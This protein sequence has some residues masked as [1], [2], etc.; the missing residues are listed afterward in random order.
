MTTSYSPEL[1]SELN[2]YYGR[3]PDRVDTSARPRFVEQRGQVPYA[4]EILKNTDTVFTGPIPKI[5]LSACPPL[6][7]TFESGYNEPGGSFEL[8]PFPE[9]EESRFE[10][11]LLYQPRSNLIENV[12]DRVNERAQF[13]KKMSD[14]RR[15]YL[16]RYNMQREVARTQ[17]FR[18]PEY[19]RIERGKYDDYPRTVT[20]FY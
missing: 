12:G 11:P 15:I 2:Q 10:S 9:K 20:E 16:S 8:P 4:N 7:S 3:R 17:F 13:L 1:A 6:K 14:P 18:T 5:P 19:V